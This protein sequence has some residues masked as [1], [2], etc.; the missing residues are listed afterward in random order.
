MVGSSRRLEFIE[1]GLRHLFQQLQTLRREQHP[2]VDFI[3]TGRVKW[4][5]VKQGYGFI[6]R[7][8]NGEDIFVHRLG[9]K[10]NNSQKLIPSLG[11]GESVWFDVGLSQGRQHQEAF[12]VTGP[13]SSQVQGSHHSPNRQQRTTSLSDVSL[14]AD[15]DNF[16][17][18]DNAKSRVPLTQSRFW[19]EMETDATTTSSFGSSRSEEDVPVPQPS[20][21]SPEHDDPSDNSFNS[22]NMMSAEDFNSEV[23]LVDVTKKE[24]HRTLDLSLYC[25]R[26]DHLLARTKNTRSRSARAMKRTLDLLHKTRKWREL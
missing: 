16:D 12:N 7:D 11:D 13:F 15:E 14:D 25:A 6:T 4:F 26:V 23:P 19:V 17:S 20:L 1:H 24:C 8:D 18:E 10:R 3:I 5:N 9:I 22:M 21:P 2:L